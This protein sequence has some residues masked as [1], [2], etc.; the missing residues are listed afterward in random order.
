MQRHLCLVNNCF[1]FWR[2]DQKKNNNN[3]KSI[4]R[5]AATRSCSYENYLKTDISRKSQFKIF[6]CKVNESSYYMFCSHLF[7]EKYR[8]NGLHSFQKYIYI[9][10][11]FLITYVLPIIYFVTNNRGISRHSQKSNRICCR[12]YKRNVGSS[13]CTDTYR[14]CTF[15]PWAVK[16]ESCVY[17]HTVHTHTYKNGYLFLNMY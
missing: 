16:P 4:V 11:D 12:M 17:I 9:L 13:K 10:L 8:S 1:L 6:R 5:L 3:N 14:N 15:T 7:R 2:K